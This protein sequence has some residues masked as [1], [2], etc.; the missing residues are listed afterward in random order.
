MIKENALV[1][2]L[3]FFIF[4]SVL[5]IFSACSPES[6]PTISEQ[7]EVLST[8]YTAFTETVKIPE[9]SI[10][11]LPETEMLI[12]E[13]VT[14]IPTESVTEAPESIALPL[15]TETE[16]TE[17][18]EESIEETNPSPEYAGTIALTFDDGPGKYTE[19][20]LNILKENGGKAT[21]FI[22]GNRASYQKDT[23]K[24]MSDE[25]H[26]VGNHSYNHPSLTEIDYQE[27]IDQITIT[28]DIIESTTGKENKLVRAPYGALN[29]DVKEIAHELN[30]SLIHWSL[31]SYDWMTRDAQSVYDEL[32]SRVKDGDIILLHDIHES[33]VDAMEMVIPELINNGYK[34]VTVSELLT[35]T[36]DSLTPGIVYSNR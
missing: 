18:A 36:R 11:A 29:S 2:K 28:K 19:R 5:F 13:I 1:K 20:L 16:D 26:E 27:A 14:E 9:E 22:V 17:T 31:D 6:T 32:I 10:E 8:E 15:Q 33:T 4:C 21:F 23:L 35:E 7:T 34:L 25:G 30:V 12:T 24:R 3:I